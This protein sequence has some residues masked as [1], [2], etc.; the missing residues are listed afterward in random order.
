MSFSVVDDHSGNSGR[1]DRIAR[2][3]LLLADDAARSGSRD[4]AARLIELAYAHFD[5]IHEEP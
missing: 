1:N 4:E 2:H 5:R 3:L